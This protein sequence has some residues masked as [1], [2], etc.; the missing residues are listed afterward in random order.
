[1]EIFTMSTKRTT[2]RGNIN[3]QR[4]SSK[5]LE[6][7]IQ[8]GVR[9]GRNNLLIDAHGQHGI[10]GRIWPRYGPVSITVKGP[11]G[12]RLG[13]MGMFGT[14][15]L[16][17]GSASDDVGWLNCG[18]RITVLGDVTN[19]AHNAG[20]QGML[21]VQGGGGARCDTM[22]KRNP[23]FEPLQSWYFRDVGD[24]FAEFKAGGIAV[25]CGVDPRNPENVLGYRPCVG[26]VGGTIYVRGPVKGYS[27]SD[28]QMV[29]LTSKDWEWLTEN[30]RPYLEAIDRT[31]YYDLLTRDRSEW[32][33]II[34]Y[35]PAEKASRKGLKI[36]LED[37]R[38][39]T[40]EN[41]VGR[42]GIFGEYLDH[43]RSILPYVTTGADRRLKPVWNNEKY[44]APCAAACPTGIPTQKR[45]ALIRE[46]RMEEALALVLNY[47][48][49]PASVCGQVCPNL[50][51]QACTR[52]RFD[53][54]FDVAAMGRLSLDA[55]APKRQPPTGRRVG[56]IGC[57]PAGMS[58]AW[59]L[60]IK[61]HEVHL[62]ETANRIG[63]KMEL[64]IPRDRLP[65]EV[66][67]KELS[68]FR[69]MGIHIYTGRRVDEESFKDIYEENEVV[70]IACGAHQPRIIP[71]QGNEDIAS[72]IDFLKEVN[73]GKGPDLIGHKV[74]IIGAGNVGMDI[75][76]EAYDCGAASVIAV[77]I[78]PPASFGKEQQAAEAR[79]TQ[80]LYPKITERYDAAKRTI[81]FKDGT[82]LEAD[83]VIISIGEVPV[84]DFLPRDIHTERGY[85]VVNAI[86]QTSDVKVF[87]VGD[88]TRPGLITHAI[89]SGRRAAEAIHAMMMHTDY[90][91]EKR[92]PI[93]YERIKLS[94]YEACR[95]DGF[96]PE[97]EADRCASCGACRDCRMCENT[98]YHGAIQRIEGP[99]GEFE[100]RVLADRCI[101]CG[102][103]AG[104]CPCGVWEMAEN[105]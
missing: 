68:R 2:I 54:A 42:G 15:I 27:T 40:W 94:Y 69:E 87:A 72:G 81:S 105:I 60:A 31:D 9:E 8:G 93:P 76:C 7:R 41:E 86:G 102:F 103:C 67:Q 24:S 95:G 3:G 61:G 51:M 55:A 34:A 6:E 84:L 89:G 80:I 57:G 25:V 32:K 74:V 83:T 38:T 59:Q 29:E 12:Q 77:D 52:S 37:F 43:P 14:E 50:C 17:Q 78:Q 100:Y 18:A 92:E 73:R 88:V 62:Y 44:Q 63:G 85:I 28:V 21:Y 53:R 66:L 70:I 4:V 104:I 48:P 11:V 79:G 46:G 97:Q 10:G 91:P 64:C 101:G 5:D 96:V 30:M 56:I 20:A 45:A 90:A 47:S 13:S 26:M 49:F 82:S 36:S 35:T 33:K 16:V 65:Q 39:R 23:R 99:K 22:T 98:C 1:L 19:G 75:A 71:F 58:A